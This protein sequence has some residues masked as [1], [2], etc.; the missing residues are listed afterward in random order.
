MVCEHTLFSPGDEG[1]FRHRLGILHLHKSVTVHGFCV[2]FRDAHRHTEHT[3]CCTTSLPSSDN[4]KAGNQTYKLASQLH[5]A[6]FLKTAFWKPEN[7]T[8]RWLT[9]SSPELPP[10]PPPFLRS[11]P[12]LPPS[13]SLSVCVLRV[14]VCLGK[15]YLVTA[16]TWISSCEPYL[17]KPSKKEL[18]IIENQRR[19]M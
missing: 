14:P 10:S 3:L 9:A 19:V 16:S 11:A 6:G 17:R 18:L 8:K 1:N 7:Y 2:A 13:P 4:T 5:S 12:C 15:V